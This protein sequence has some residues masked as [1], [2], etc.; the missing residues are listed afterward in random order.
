MRRLIASGAVAVL[1]L[2][3]TVPASAEWVPH[4]LSGQ[5]AVTYLARTRLTGIMLSDGLSATSGQQISE[6]HL[7]VQFEDSVDDIC[8]HQHEAVATFTPT[9]GAAGSK[10]VYVGV[11]RAPHI[12]PYHAQLLDARGSGVEVTVVITR[13]CTLRA[14]YY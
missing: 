12:R 13:A 7:F 5:Q 6:G 11:A 14:F 4:G 1:S 9:G 8:T 3:W 10:W 2:L